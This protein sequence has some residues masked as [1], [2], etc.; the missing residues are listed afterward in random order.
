M[1]SSLGAVIVSAFLAL[2]LSE[3]K[4]KKR[5]RSL[6]ATCLESLYIQSPI[7][8]YY[9]SLLAGTPKGVS[10]TRT[11]ETLPVLFEYSNRTKPFDIPFD[12]VRENLLELNVDIADMIMRLEIR[13][14]QLNR[15]LVEW[16]EAFS[17]QRKTNYGEILKDLDANQR[18][19]GWMAEYVRL[20]AFTSRNARKQLFEGR[21]KIIVDWGSV[22]AK[23]DEMDKLYMESGGVRD[24]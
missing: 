23:D 19:Y 7:I 17:D 18:L 14:R 24:G 15:F 1:I 9:F 12:K 6:V 4:E 3:R 21:R 13:V 8:E 16:T 5:S 11:K 20:L 2:Y 22:E 10:W